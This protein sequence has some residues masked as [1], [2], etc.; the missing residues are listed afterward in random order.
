MR[1]PIL[2]S[3]L[4][5]LAVLVAVWEFWLFPS[6][7]IRYRLTLDVAVGGKVRT[8]SGVIETVWNDQWIKFPL[9][10][11]GVP[12]GV[13]V[14][15]EAVAVDLGSRGILFALL[16]ADETRASGPDG[17]D[18]PPSFLVD[19]FYGP[20]GQGGATRQMLSELKSRRDV[21]DV[22]PGLLP[23]LVRFRDINDPKS[24]ERVEPS[25]LAKSFGPD[26]KLVRLGSSCADGV[27][28]IQ[29]AKRRKS[30]VAIRGAGDDK[31]QG[32]VPWYRTQTGYISRNS[33][34]DIYRPEQNLGPTDFARGTR[35]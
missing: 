1:T 8:G 17:W 20:V 14:R 22:P 24:V 10:P 2:V 9:A 5:V 29:L 16:K 27:L 30:A 28:A 34:I 12:W 19:A 21:V 3:V 25:D 18:L 6:W 7:T 32:L 11:I 26:V 35:Q 13:D 4:G 31:D 23:M 33:I 15:G